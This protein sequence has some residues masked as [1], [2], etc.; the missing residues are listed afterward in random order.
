MHPGRQPERI[1]MAESGDAEATRTIPLLEERLAVGRRV[2]ETGR[3]RVHLST[4]TEDAVV[5][6]ALRDERVEI[7]RVPVGREVAAAPA[8]REEE[9]GAVLVVPVLEEVLVVERRLVLKKELRIR[10]VSSRRTSEQT[11][12]LRRQ[13]ATVE[14]LPAQPDA[15]P[16]PPCAPSRRRRPDMTTMTLTALY[17]TRS[18]ADQ[19]VERLT[20][21]V[22][23]SRSNVAVMAQEPTAFGGSATAGGTE[24]TGFLASLKELFM[25]EDDRHAYSEAIR[26]GGFLLTATVEEGSAERAMDILEEHG[27]VDLDDRREAWR[28]EGWTG[29]QGPMGAQT[30]ADGTVAATTSAA[31][32]TATTPAGARAAGAG[33]EET[34]ALV[35]ERLRVG[36]RSVEGGRVRVRSYVVEAPVQEQVPLR[37]ENIAI[38][39]R[40]VDRPVTDADQAAF[41][42]RTIEAT[43]TSEEAV[44][45][46]TA[47]VTEEVV[48]SKGAKERV[49]TVRDTV[50]RTEVEVDDDRASARGA[51]EAAAA[52][53][54]APDTG[55]AATPG[56]PM[57]PA[58][59]R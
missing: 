41:G 49:E 31:T 7:K 16:E 2:V 13:T 33:E 52:V 54:G 9:D 18:E 37:E 24:G 22:G 17:D 38:E 15:D 51:A 40:A 59:R 5:R 50:R 12:P 30:L 58:A 29:H 25:P 36:K 45:S 42:D 27:A 11:M 39:R 21:E 56:K 35:E 32:A 4:T 8:I 14:R 10:R 6:E 26:R 46:K 53:P 47:R 44:V 43:A 55:K 19:A 48:V 3:V 57:N 23:I 20:R 34:I 28:A 1:I